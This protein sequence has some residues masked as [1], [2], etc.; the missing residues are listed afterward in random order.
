[1]ERPERKDYP[2]PDLK[3]VVRQPDYTEA[4]EKYSVWAESQLKEREEKKEVVKQFME[5]YNNSEIGFECEHID[6]LMDNEG[7]EICCECGE[8]IYNLKP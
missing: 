3:G 8:E 6:T 2:H 4:I 1:M 7:N 5:E